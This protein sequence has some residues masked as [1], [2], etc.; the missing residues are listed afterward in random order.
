MERL[1]NAHYHQYS[2]LIHDRTGIHIAENKRQLLETRLGR[3]LYRKRI[4]SP[5]AY[6]RIL[7]NPANKLEFQEFVDAMT[8]NTTE[9][10]RENHHFE[11]L[12]READRWMADNP[13]IR[14]EREIRIWS[15]GCSTGQE[16]VTLRMLMEDLFGDEIR[17]ILLAT[18]ISQKVLRKAVSGFYSDQEAEG[19]PKAYL[20]RHFLRV[21]GG[22]QLEP[23]ILGD[24][25]YRHFNL[26][27]P[28]P[29]RKGFDMIF[30]RNVMIYFDLETQQSL[31][32]KFYNALPSGGLFFIGHSE[33][34]INKRH[35]FRHLGPSLYQR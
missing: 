29:F 21:A 19:I 11:F 5:E 15:A 12:Q 35:H 10:F 1:K 25:R 6:L 27:E 23:A 14:R 16:A 2:A 20:S 31:I 18:D 33:S 4:E 9:F 22:W 17:V 30:C 26:M 8:T 24:I 7:E 28:F 13:R 32:T 34:L 3:L